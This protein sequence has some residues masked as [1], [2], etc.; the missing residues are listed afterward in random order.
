MTHKNRVFQ[1]YAANRG[2]PRKFQVLAAEEPTIY[3]YDMIVGSDAEAEVWGGVSPEA[4][5]RAVREIEAKR[6]HLRIDSPGGDAFAATAMAVALAQHPAQVIAHVDGYAASAATHVAI[7][8]DEIEIADGGM[9]MIH[10]AWTMALGNAADMRQMAD[11]LD[12]VDESQ[13][14]RYS[15]RTGKS[16]EAMLELM[17]AETWYSA[18]EAVE[19]GFADRV[20]QSV[21]A[22]SQWDLSAYAHAPRQEA[23][24]A[25]IGQQ[26]ISNHRRALKLALVG[27]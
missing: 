17:A 12:K 4:F 22:R 2:R 16:A 14:K 9:W 23:P 6:I 3:L 1:L 5:S 11:L 26:D 18:E 19:A 15:K 10:N 13:A 20:M 27:V 25:A 8:A 21:K 7:A 24:E